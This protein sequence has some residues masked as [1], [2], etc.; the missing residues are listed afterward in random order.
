MGMGHE[1]YNLAHGLKA[2]HDSSGMFGFV[3][4]NLEVCLQAVWTVYLF[5]LARQ[6]GHVGMGQ[7]GRRFDKMHI[8][9]CMYLR[10]SG[11][12]DVG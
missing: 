5:A 4:F 10:S 6:D 3:L 1:E 9:L 2:V 8:A 7:G 11:H 12:V